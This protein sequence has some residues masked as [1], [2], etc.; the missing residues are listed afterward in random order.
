MCKSRFTHYKRRKA[1]Y[2]LIL[3]TEHKKSF[4]GTMLLQYAE[5][6]IEYGTLDEW[7]ERHGIEYTRK[8][9]YRKDQGILWNL[10]EGFQGFVGEVELIG[11]LAL[12]ILL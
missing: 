4:V 9:S 1:K 12:F 7:C 5:N 8:L 2:E 6:G 11:R 3:D 10:R